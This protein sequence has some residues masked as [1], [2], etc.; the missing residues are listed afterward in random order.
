VV[1][2]GW[3]LLLRRRHAILGLFAGETNGAAA[4]AAAATAAEKGAEA[5]KG[6]KAAAGRSSYVPAG[7]QRVDACACCE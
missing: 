4:A 5:T 6:M 2:E 3:K 7:R 1:V